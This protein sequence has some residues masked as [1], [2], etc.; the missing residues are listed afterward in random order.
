MNSFSPVPTNL[1]DVPLPPD[2][3]IDDGGNTLDVLK[4][5]CG[6][7]TRD[8]PKEFWV[9]PADR[10]DKSRE[11]D[12]NHT[13]PINYVDR[14]TN[15]NPTHECTCH[16]LTRNAEGA[17]NKQRGIIFPDGPKKD[18]RYEESKQGSVWLSPLSIYAEANPRQWGGANVRQVLEIACRRGFLPEKIQP[19]EYG[20]K[21]SLQGTTGQG[22]LNQSKGPW[23]RLSNFPEGHEETSKNF[24]PLEVVFPE[25]WEEALCLVLN[26][27][28]VSVGRSGHAVPWAFW[29]E[30]EQVMG[31]VDS[32]D[33]VR[34]DSLRTVKSAWQGSFA[35]V[36]MTTPDDWDKPAG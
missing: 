9:E 22:G 36:S 2:G 17:R 1:I 31:Y 11:N 25:S 16:S 20:F 28:L 21:H 33:V 26:G 8:F 30:A 15:Q 6:A 24:K 23:V 14:F 19:R 35:I 3:Y 29:N 18:F 4:A 13:W 12:K 7:A 34:Y 27:V 10:A 5:M 32:Y